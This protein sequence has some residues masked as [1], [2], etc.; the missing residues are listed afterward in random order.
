MST[1]L[2]QEIQKRHKILDHLSS[3]SLQFYLDNVVINS[4]P[5]PRRWGDIRES[6]QDDL[7]APKVPMFENLAGIQAYEGPGSFFDCLARGHDK[8]SLEGRFIAW[9]LAYSRRT[10]HGY[11]CA[12]DQDQG[13]LIL[14]AIQDE[15]RLN[16]WIGCKIKI[17][18]GV[19]SGPAGDVTV[20]PAD[21]GSAFGFRG[22][23]YIFDE[24]TN[25]SKPNHQKLW[26][27]VV[28]GTEKVQPRVLGILSNA[29]YI[30]S[31]Q[32]SVWQSANTDPDYTCFSRWGQLAKWMPEDRVKALRD[33]LPSK[34]EGRRVFDNEWVRM[35]EEFD[36]LDLADCKLCVDDNLIYKL[37]RH[38]GRHPTFISIDYGPRRDSTVCT[39]GHKEGA[40]VIIDRMDN[41]GPVPPSAVSMWCDK[42]IP[43]FRPITEWVLDPYQLMFL[44]E[45][46]QQAGQNVF[47]WNPRAG[48]AN[49]ELSQVL[50]T[51]I[52]SRQVLWYPGCGNKLEEELANLIIV[53]KSYGF[54]I[55]HASSKHDD[56]AV[57]LGQLLCRAQNS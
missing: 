45:K 43:L 41:L 36:Y 29:G 4:S 3:L 6:W 31:W 30:D 12:A 53:K 46:L 5:V 57:S 17:R 23:L 47:E 27:A 54:R 15:L 37:R 28:S 51:S 16:P 38:P 20:V 11:I 22:N 14:Q 49:N 39:V 19:V 50:R 40:K 18:K 1:E 52:L 21:A 33:K 48:A 10:I 35:G 55:D 7:I 2:S 25:W 42:I 56:Q 26:D 8:S 32:H 44:S 9:L 34:A 13:D 24:L